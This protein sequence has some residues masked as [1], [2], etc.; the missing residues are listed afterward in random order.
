MIKLPENKWLMLVVNPCDMLM[1]F[2]L[3]SAFAKIIEIPDFG[4]IRVLNGLKYFTNNLRHMP[5]LIEEMKS[6]SE[7]KSLL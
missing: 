1:L 5:L 3:Q 4:P 2:T 7:I 6:L